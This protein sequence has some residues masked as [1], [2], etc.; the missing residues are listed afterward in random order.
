MLADRGHSSARGLGH[1][2]LAG[3]RVT[4][5]VNAG[6]LPLH[7]PEGEPFDLLGAVST[8]GRPHS[9]WRDLRFVLNHLACAIEPRS[10]LAD[11]NAISEA[12]A[13]PPRPRMPR[14]SSRFPDA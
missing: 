1:V 10:S 3:G 6:S 2:A 13:E 8:L 5:R 14:L 4:V 7:G 11:W 12:L 9:A